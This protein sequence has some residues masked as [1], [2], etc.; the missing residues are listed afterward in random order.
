M[1]KNLRIISKLHANFHTLTKTPVKFQNDEHK[2][3]LE[4]LCKLNSH[5]I[6]TLIVYKSNCE[7]NKNNLRIIS[8][9]HAHLQS[10]TKHLLNFKR[11]GIKLSEKLRK[12]GTK[13]LDIN[14]AHNQK[15]TQKIVQSL[16]T[17]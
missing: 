4:E 10:M 11:I 14:T 12:Q 3:L 9:L 8:E 17:Q 1:T 6:F 7:S 16:C 15:Q 13:S 2:K 5:Y